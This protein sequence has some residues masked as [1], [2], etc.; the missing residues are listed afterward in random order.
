MQT[1]RTF[2]LESKRSFSEGDCRKQS[3]LLFSGGIVPRWAASS[4]FELQ[5][6]S[7]RPVKRKKRAL[8]WRSQAFLRHLGE[9]TAGVRFS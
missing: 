4:T 7:R 1:H 3:P 5:A 6:V 9:L 8:T 2:R